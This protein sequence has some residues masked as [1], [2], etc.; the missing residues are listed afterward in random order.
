MLKQRRVRRQPRHSRFTVNHSSLASLSLRPVC[1]PG[2][3]SCSQFLDICLTKIEKKA[4]PIPG[5]T[6]TVDIGNAPDAHN[7]EHAAHAYLNRRLREVGFEK[8]DQTASRISVVFKKVGV[9][10]YEF[11][12]EIIDADLVSV[13]IT[14]FNAA[15]KQI[16]SIRTEPPAP[17]SQRVS[18]GATKLAM[19]IAMYNRAVS[20]ILKVKLPTPE[21]LRAE[22][23]NPGLFQSEPSS[24]DMAGWNTFTSPQGRYSVLLPGQV[25]KAPTTKGMAFGS[26]LPDGTSFMVMYSDHDDLDIK[27]YSSE[28][29]IVARDAAADGEE[30]LHDKAIDLNGHP[31][32]EF[33]FADSDNDMSHVRI[34]LV[35]QRMYQLIFLVPR[36][37]YSATNKDLQRFMGSFQLLP[38]NPPP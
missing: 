9:Q 33:G 28:L 11:G 22:E 21:E 3:W 26:D 13:E 2:E 7:I 36:W 37:K 38:E 31:G 8:G 5:I 4:D 23:K 15:G 18:S 1:S 35:G 32:R 24:A 27:S 19:K 30:L 14:F 12:R 6:V 25:Q 17:N 16:L 34:F 10:K 20:G 29:L